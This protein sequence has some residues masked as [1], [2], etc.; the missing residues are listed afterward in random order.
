ME[1]R[2]RANAPT[3][4]VVPP[5]RSSRPLHRCNQR[6]T[7]VFL[8]PAFAFALAL[9]RPRVPLLVVNAHGAQ[10][11]LRQPLI[12]LFVYRIDKVPRHIHSL[13]ERLGCFGANLQL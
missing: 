1:P 4:S 2:R 6:T 5:S 9:G 3:Q 7:W 11:T 8:R 13:V 10:S 12:V